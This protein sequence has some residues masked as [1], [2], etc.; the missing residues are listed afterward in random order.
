MRK[1]IRDRIKRRARW[2]VGVALLGWFLAAVP[3]F[4]GMATRPTPPA[5]IGA[6]VLG[7]LVFA[8]AFIAMMFIRCPKC[9][10]RI[11]HT[12]A[13][14]VGF[15]FGGLRQRINYCPYCGVNLDEACPDS[16]NPITA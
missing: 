16:G 2:S 14:P 5:A 3:G 8:G 6:S 10:A 1:T 9:S 12:I 13:V 11:S 7:F 15:S 4:I